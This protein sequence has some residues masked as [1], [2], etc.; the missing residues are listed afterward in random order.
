MIASKNLCKSSSCG[1][2]L[3]LLGLVV[4]QLHSKVQANPSLRISKPLWLWG[5]CFGSDIANLE[6][7]KKAAL[8]ALLVVLRSR[9]GA[10]NVYDFLFTGIK[11][12]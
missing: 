1:G 2:I 9:P 6:A 11:L 7:A 4:T 10:L 3:R 8:A 5:I 12:T